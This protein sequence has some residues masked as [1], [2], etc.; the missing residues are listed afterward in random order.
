MK[1]LKAI[2]K[3]I[4]Y[5]SSHDTGAITAYQSIHTDKENQLRNRRLL[6]KLM[7][8]DYRVTSIK[9]SFFENH[10]KPNSKE[11]YAEIFFIVDLKN[12]GNLESELENRG[13]EFGLDSVLIIP[14]GSDVSYYFETKF[15]SKVWFRPFVFS[16][17]ITEHQSPTNVMGKWAA[18]LASK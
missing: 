16:E 5:S 10:G 13:Q 8:N 1:N 6:A 15:L 3:I 2:D 18:G 7:L 14:K 17:E 4:A 11:I 9:G 12:K